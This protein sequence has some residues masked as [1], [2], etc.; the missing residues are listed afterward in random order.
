MWERG[1]CKTWPKSSLQMATL[2]TVSPLV[3]RDNTLYLYIPSRT[4][5]A[6]DCISPMLSVSLS[7]SWH[8]HCHQE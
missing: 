4:K 1:K 2:V 8:S 6:S 3:T 7:S 5:D